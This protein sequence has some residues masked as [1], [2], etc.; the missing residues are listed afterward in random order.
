MNAGCGHHV[1][2]SISVCLGN[3]AMP[4]LVHAAASKEPGLPSVGNV[5]L[6]K[7]KHLQKLCMQLFATVG[8]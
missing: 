1:M 3:L 6:W 8:H 7:K 4:V 5:S 2:H